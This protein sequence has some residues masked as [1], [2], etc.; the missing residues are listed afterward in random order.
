MCFVYAA[1]FVS[2]NAIQECNKEGK[3]R[4]RLARHW[5]FPLEHTVVPREEVVNLSNQSMF[6]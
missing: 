3:K 6:I 5:M 2:L 1:I 4:Q